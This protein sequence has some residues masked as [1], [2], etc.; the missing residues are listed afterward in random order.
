MVSI[1]LVPDY[2][3]RCCLYHEKTDGCYFL[4]LINF[5]PVS[6]K[7]FEKKKIGIRVGA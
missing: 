5:F 1:I 6:I 4:R 2:E 3:K 7:V